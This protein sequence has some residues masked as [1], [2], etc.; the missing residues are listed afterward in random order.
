MA[1]DG[2]DSLVG[3]GLQE[4]GGHHLFDGED[5]AVLAV[6]ADGGA[7]ILDGLDGVLDLE[8]AAVRGEDGVEEVVA[9]A[10]GR[11]EEPAGQPGPARA[12]AAGS[13]TMAARGGG[14]WSRKDGD[15]D[16][17]AAWEEGLAA[18]S[19]RWGGREGEAVVEQASK[20]AS[21]KRQAAS[22]GC[23]GVQ[24]VPRPWGWGGAAVVVASRTGCACLRRRETRA[25]GSAATSGGW[26]AARLTLG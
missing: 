16:V 20:Q 3:A 21:K 11:L 2:G 15:G 6:D 8:V 10:Y 4:L 24:Y 5:D 12:G 19:G 13:R 18:R 7:A 22:G 9:G 23:V 26:C 14:V 1:V 17:Q 25:A